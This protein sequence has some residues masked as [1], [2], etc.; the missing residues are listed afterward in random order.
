MRTSI[1]LSSRPFTNHRIFWIALFVVYF[2]GLWLFL[3]MAS[4]K[5]RV[6]AKADSV[7]QRIEGQE[8][9]AKAAVEEQKR[10]E[11]DKQKIVVTEQQAMELA[12]AR[13]LIQRKS[14]S[15]NKIISDIEEYI[16][17]NT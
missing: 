2:T 1:N 9:L 6:I 14:F 15:W 8:K 11:Q 5:N 12:G 13:Q 16:P 4:E 10:R 17:K 3:W 7:K